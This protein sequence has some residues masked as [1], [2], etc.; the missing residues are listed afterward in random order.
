[1]KK[2]LLFTFILLLSVSLLGCANGGN[3]PQP[4]ENTPPTE[5]PQQETVSLKDFFPLSKGSTWKYLGEGNEYA[6]FNRKV[7]FV[8]GD[9]AQTVEDNGGTV[10]ASIFKTTENEIIRTFFQGEESNE[11]NLLDQ[12]PND[13]LVIL[14]APLSVG[15]KWEVQEGV[16]EIVEIDAIV[17]T[18]A[19]KFEGCIKVSIKM[20]NSTMNE[21][22]KA[23]V[24]MVKREFTSEGMVVTS[25]LEKY[26]IK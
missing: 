13:T 2:T 18:P 21:Y 20:Q 25:T 24:G 4:A 16:R 11:T 26:D 23:G 15:T 17:D 10:S 1:M 6:S 19:G 14:K 8:E 3:P 9:R 12:K 22:F 5:G 7:L